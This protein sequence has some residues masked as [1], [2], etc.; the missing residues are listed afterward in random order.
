[1]GYLVGVRNVIVRNNTIQN[2]QTTAPVYSVGD[3]ASRVRTGHA[4]IEVHSLATSTELADS[5]FAAA[6]AIDRSWS[7]QQRNQH[8]LRWHPLGVGAGASAPRRSSATRWRR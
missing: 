4:G 7:K 2:V 8:R 3:L 6:I 1:M 5:A